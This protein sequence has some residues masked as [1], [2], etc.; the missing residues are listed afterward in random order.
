VDTLAESVGPFKGR[1]NEF[2]VNKG[3]KDF[4]E[5]AGLDIDLDLFASALV[6]THFG[7]RGGGQ[8]REAL[9]HMLAE[10]Q[11]PEDLKA[12]ITHADKWLLGYA[13]IKPAG[14]GNAPGNV[15]MTPTNGPAT[16]AKSLLEKI[17]KQKEAA[18]GKP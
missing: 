1:W 6:R 7:A 18:Q 8:Y 15:D 2:M 4:P 17:R 9:K 10:S 5:F 3:G 12:R 16:D 14:H 13:N 11:S